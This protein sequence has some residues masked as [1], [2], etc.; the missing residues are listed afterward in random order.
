MQTS[1]SEISERKMIYSYG[2]EKQKKIRA[3]Y[4]LITGLILFLITLSGLTDGLSDW[5]N[6]YLFDKLGY[7]DKWTKTFG[8]RL[9][10][11]TMNDIAALSGKVFIFISILL[12]SIY[13]RIRREYKLYWEFLSVMLGGIFFLIIIKMLFANE[14]PYNPMELITTDIGSY[15]SGHA[16]MAMIFYLTIAVLS[17][18]KQRRSKVRRFTFVSVLIIILLV[19]LSRIFGAAHN[20]GEV[21]AGWSLGLIW[22]CTCWLIERYIRINYPVDKNGI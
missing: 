9:L 8:P 6:S 2:V 12:V 18:R 11:L 1:D 21:L 16:F 7:T 3:Y 20:F 22:V 10:V 14:I 19:G 13:Y 17:S 4:L 15:P 5:I